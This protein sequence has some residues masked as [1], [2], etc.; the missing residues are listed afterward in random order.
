MQD[1]ESSSK[2]YMNEGMT[3][4]DNSIF[5]VELQGR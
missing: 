4:M 3:Y 5:L 1:N 2:E